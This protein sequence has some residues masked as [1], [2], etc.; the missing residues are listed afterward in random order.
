[1]CEDQDNPFVHSP[2]VTDLDLAGM[3]ASYPA[4]GSSRMASFTQEL[5]SFNQ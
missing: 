2:D 4:A 1:M 5:S 3:S